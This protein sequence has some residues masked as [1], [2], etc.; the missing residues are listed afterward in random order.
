[1]PLYL[2]MIGRQLTYDA[3]KII[4]FD[5]ALAVTL[6]GEMKFIQ[7]LAQE[8]KILQGLIVAEKAASS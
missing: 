4:G 6:I 1:M 3:L 5:T 2:D 8:G 7:T